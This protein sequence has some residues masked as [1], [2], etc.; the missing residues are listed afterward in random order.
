MSDE[1]KELY[2]WRNENIAGAVLVDGDGGNGYRADGD[3][4]GDSEEDE[5]LE[6]RLRVT[7]Y[8]EQ[9]SGLS[10]K[11]YRTMGS[12]PESQIK[13]L[14]CFMVD[15]NGRFMSTE[16]AIEI[17]DELT[18]GDIADAYEELQE[19]IREAVVPKKS[20]K[21]SGKARISKYR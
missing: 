7:D 1:T 6:I 4:D 10:G 5:T 13:F 15:E 8:E 17:L 18:Y 16:Q 3:G 2:N 12:N 9:I 21:R 20:G 14:A 11:E 19:A